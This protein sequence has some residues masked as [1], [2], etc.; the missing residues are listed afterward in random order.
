MPQDAVE[1]VCRAFDVPPGR[2][3]L[4][5]I[6]PS[7]LVAAADGT[8]DPDALWSLGRNA[9]TLGIDPE[10]AAAI[11][12]VQKILSA[13]MKRGGPE[14]LDIIMEAVCQLIMGRPAGERLAVVESVKDTCILTAKS[15]GEALKTKFSGAERRIIERIFK[16]LDRCLD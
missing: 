8:I 16:K 9:V 11:K 15:S 6:L 2:P 4:A 3:E 13:F 5:Y 12:H 7:F 1:T 14:H 10:D